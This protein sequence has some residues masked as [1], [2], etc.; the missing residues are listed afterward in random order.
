MA[1]FI[2]RTGAEALIP[3]ET[4]KE[5]IQG[6]IQNSAVLTR[7]KRLANMSSK[8]Q[9]MPVLEML[10][11]AY[12]TD[13][14]TGFAKPSKQMWDK[15]RITAAE[16]KVLVPIPESVLDDMQ[17]SGYDFE[18]EVLPRI[19]EAI[20]KTID[21]AVIWGVNKPADWRTP[22]VQTAI[23]AGAVVNTTNDIYADI[24]G[25]G[26]VFAKVEESG[27]EC[28][29]CLAGIKF[30]STLRGLRDDNKQPLFKKDMAAGTAYSLD[31]NPI[32]FS[33]NG[34]W[35][36][37]IAK[38]I[39]GDFTQAVYA[40]RKDMK[41]RLLTE[42]VIQDPSTKEIVWNLAQQG[43]VALL[44]TC[45]LGWELPNPITAEN[46]DKTT[47][48][49]F[50]VYSPAVVSTGNKVTFTVKDN[51]ESPAAVGG[52]SVELDGSFKNA[53][54]SGVAEFTNIPDG[55]YKYTV[56]GDGYKTAKGTVTVNGAA[57][58]VAVTLA[59]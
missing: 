59:Q 5:I 35:D 53:N 45:R 17:D 47:R 58:S 19:N 25:E 40:F 50:A 14:D 10:P 28:N 56:K 6:A 49:P 12:F 27:F 24:M 8:T 9:S 29:G 55:V 16:L 37:N 41:V 1:Q 34:T 7:F 30:K 33:T 57:A 36:N 11:L 4:T 23:N 32:S 44:V 18:G 22:L 48:L 52:A 26:G 31:G 2:D 21:G 13:G 20:G 42:G 39:V 38:L 3:E 51:A 46:D 43:M 15:K 54:T